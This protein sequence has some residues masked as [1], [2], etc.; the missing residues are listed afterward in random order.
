MGRQA[1]RILELRV[2]D[3]LGV[4]AVDITNDGGPV[5]L[6]GDN[7]AGKS[8][9]LKALATVL[10]G[11]PHEI[12]DPVRHG[13]K[14]A[15]ICADIGDYVAI[16]EAERGK[17]ERIRLETKEGAVIKRPREALLKIVGDVSFDP[18]SILYMTKPELRDTLLRVAG[19]DVTGFDERESAA[20]DARRD[21]KRDAAR[22]SV[23]LNSMPF[24]SGAPDQDISVDELHRELARALEMRQQ[25]ADRE[26]ALGEAKRKHADAAKEARRIAQKAEE[27]EKLLESATDERVAAIE[28]LNKAADLAI[29]AEKDFGN[30]PKAPDI[31]G[32]QRRMR[33]AEEVNAKVRQNKAR[34]IQRGKAAEAEARY[35]E[36]D[37]QV[38]AIRDERAESLASARMPI[39]GLEV[40]TGDKGDYVTLDGVPFHQANSAAKIRACVAIGAALSPDFR[41]AV[42]ESGNDLDDQSMADLISACAERDIDL[43]IERIQ[44]H[45]SGSIIIEDGTVQG[46]GNA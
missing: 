28:A 40:R 12:S 35:R 17:P 33:E 46:D 3:F 11:R 4:S 19:V 20:F 14:K 43:W 10:V 41:V 27:L 25:V 34:E 23:A 30:T 7:G 5:V 13:K 26:R 22:E 32:I 6:S 9:V 45:G 15:E 39:D 37:D 38:K 2:K 18:L 8:S 42:V 21:A 24:D 16:W 31:E 1:S 44:P 36:L 29:Q